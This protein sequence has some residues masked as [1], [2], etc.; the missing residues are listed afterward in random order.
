MGSLD[1]IAILVLVGIPVLDR[2][3]V[4]RL[5]VWL[6]FHESI[7]VWSQLT[8]HVLLEQ[9]VVSGCKMVVLVVLY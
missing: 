2:I 9:K 1:C 6:E 7:R 4:S 8:N 5:L 3:L